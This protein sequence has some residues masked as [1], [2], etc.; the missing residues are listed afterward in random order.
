MFVSIKRNYS[1][2]I[3]SAF[4]PSIL[5]WVLAYCTLFMDIDDI[6]NRSRTAVTVLLVLI[7]LLQTVKRDFPKTTYFKYIDLW[8]LW[9]TSNIFLITVFHVL[10]LNC[11]LILTT[12]NPDIVIP[13]ESTEKAEKHENMDNSA[14]KKLN[15]IAVFLLP[16]LM[17]SF[18]VVYF[19]LTV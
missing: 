4:C 14:K 15:K 7:S 18:N 13:F 19:H 5:F 6:S 17:V 3:I 8:F 16:I 10:L 9:Y 11:N 1:D 12:K 2:Q